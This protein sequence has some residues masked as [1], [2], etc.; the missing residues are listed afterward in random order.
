MA[1]KDLQ[2]YS[3]NQVILTSDRLVFNARLDNIFLITKKDVAISSGG[4][5]HINVGEEVIVN[6]PKTTFG[7]GNDAQPVA[8]ADSLVNTLSNIIS[9]LSK[10]LTTL[11]T[12]KGLVTGGTA[13]LTSVNTA[14]ASLN[15]KLSNILKKLED[16][17]S[18]TVYA[19]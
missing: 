7:L 1:F 19:N 10:F 4:S 9:E 6:S 3:A 18:K 13:E 2:K 15:S 16:I 11:T 14:A 5:F 12:A 8:K 17:K